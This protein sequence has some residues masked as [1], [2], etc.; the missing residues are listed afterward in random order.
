MKDR[1]KP[2]FINKLADPHGFAKK[3]RQETRPETMILAILTLAPHLFRSTRLRSGPKPGRKARNRQK[4]ER[5]ILERL[6]TF[7]EDV[8]TASPW[9][10]VEAR[11]R[12]KLKA[13][14]P[15]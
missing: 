4:N 2:I 14:Q 5:I 8:K 3:K 6:A 9:P 1:L 12:R 10:E 15:R 7:D 13:P 11:I